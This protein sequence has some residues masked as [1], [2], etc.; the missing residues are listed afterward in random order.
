[1]QTSTRYNALVARIAQIQTHLLPAVRADLSYSNQELDL[2]RA[3]CLLCH[4]EF[5]AYLE[6]IALEVTKIAIDKWKTNKEDITPIIFHLAYSYRNEVGKKREPPYN[7][8]MLAYKDLEAK[9]K[10]NNGIKEDNLA[11]FFTPI[12]FSV[13]ST[14]QT[15]LNDYGSTRGQIAHTSFHT[16]QPLDPSTERSKVAL[17]MSGLRVMDI[18][19]FNYER[20]GTSQRKAI[21]IHWRLSLRDRIRILFKGK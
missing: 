5:E 7:M 12:G 21:H 4:A 15:T 13:D 14:L 11:G 8:V 18:D 1:M 16:Q 3:F 10:K 6:D 20:T 17:I 9:V 2:T 19:L